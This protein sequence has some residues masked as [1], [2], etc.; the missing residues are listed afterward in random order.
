M[1]FGRGYNGFNNC[2]RFGYGFTHF[3]FGMFMMLG[4]AVLIVIAIIYFAKRAGNRSSSNAMEELKMRFAKGEISE[5]EYL[6]K[7][8]IL[9]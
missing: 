1:M 3:G 4:F 2:F 8:D 6:K 7:K 9:K 5:E